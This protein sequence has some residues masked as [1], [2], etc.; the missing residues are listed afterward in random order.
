MCHLGIC[1]MIVIYHNTRKGT[2]YMSHTHVT[3]KHVPLTPH[4]NPVQCSST[5]SFSHSLMTRTKAQKA[6]HTRAN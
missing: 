5:C 6:T 1:P 3:Y 4:P 2:P